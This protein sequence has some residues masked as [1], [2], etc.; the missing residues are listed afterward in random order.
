MANLSPW[1]AS[2]HGEPLSTENLSPRRTS[3]HGE[4]LSTANLSPRRTSLPGEPPSTANISTWRTSL[5][6]DPFL[7]NQG[8]HFVVG[9][10]D[11]F[12]GQQQDPRN[13]AELSETKSADDG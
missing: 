3:L 13:R 1:R 7:V 9:I 10:N 12:P 6:G 8:V 11:R 5:Y 2:L 4:P